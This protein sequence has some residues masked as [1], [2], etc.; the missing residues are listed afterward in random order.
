[1]RP[2]MNEV[3]IERPRRGMRIKTR[4]NNKPRAAEYVDDDSYSRELRPTPRRTKRF[5]DHLGP[6]RRWLRSQV[7]RPWDKVWSELCA[8]IDQRS[9]TGRHLLGHAR[10]EVEIECEVGEDRKIYATTGWWRHRRRAPVE[11]LYVH[12]HTGL[13]RWQEPM[14]QQER[15]RKQ[16]AELPD[17]DI[18][19]LPDGDVLWRECGIWF[20]VRAE[21]VPWQHRPKV[22]AWDYELGGNRM[23]IVDKR[24]LN[25]RQ[26]REYGLTNAE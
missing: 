24:Q 3:L 13:L 21:I 12:P 9:V 7:N 19:D 23:R 26:L 10:G 18:R 4:R 17:P 15:K 6:L 8:G 16:W 11:G 25:H 22:R 2:D 20:R 5:D 1:M 14:S